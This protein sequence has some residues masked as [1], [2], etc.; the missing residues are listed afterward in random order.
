MTAAP[1]SSRPLRLVDGAVDEPTDAVLLAAVA[2][3][4]ERACRVFVERHA[5]RV[6]GVAMAVCRDRGVAEDVAQRAFEQA[7]RHAGS[8]DPDRASARTWLG[9]I[10]R[11]VAIDEVRRRRPSPVSPEDLGRLLA[12]SGSDTERSGLAA[13]ERDQV[14]A[15]LGALPEE[16][17][18]AVVLAGIGGLS[19]REVADTES[20]P[21]GT[22][23]TRIRLGMRRMRAALA[24]EVDRG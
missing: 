6:I 10:A 15:A 12:P 7:W 19:A 18:R 24:G 9:T 2:T 21:L 13:L 5:S 14:A 11:R 20:V 16:Q 3:G 23:K 8:Y 17:R 4:D 22:A 1:R